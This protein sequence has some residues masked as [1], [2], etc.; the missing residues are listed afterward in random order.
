MQE[1]D[2]IA[3]FEV[4]ESCIFPHEKWTWEQRSGTQRKF[5][6][7]DQQEKKVNSVPQLLRTGFCQQLN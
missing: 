7:D 1:R 4:R 5:P 6:D 2:S 3:F